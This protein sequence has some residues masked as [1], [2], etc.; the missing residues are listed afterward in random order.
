MPTA[1]K[2]EATCPRC[3]GSGQYSYHQL[4]GTVCFGCQGRGVVQ[5]AAAKAAET[6]ERAARRAENL[7]RVA[8]AHNRETERNL[9][10]I[11]KRIERLEGDLQRC[12][13]R[14]L[15]EDCFE[16][17]RQNINAEKRAMARYAAYQGKR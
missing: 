16:R 6:T 10:L 17:V 4:H 15:T 5:V 11:R 7:A 9:E 2:T 3:G 13:E 1:T 14:N 12:A 8:E